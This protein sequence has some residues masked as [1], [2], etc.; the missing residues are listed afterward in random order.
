MEILPRTSS[1]VGGGFPNPPNDPL[2]PLPFFP[3]FRLFL[4]AA[5]PCTHN[6]VGDGNDDSS[7]TNSSSAARSNKTVADS[8]WDLLFFCLL[9]AIVIIYFISVGKIARQTDLCCTVF[10]RMSNTQCC[11]L[12]CDTYQ[13]MVMART[14]D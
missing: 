2:F 7:R 8:G 9:A 6:V 12:M 11:G 1:R 13:V 10:Y 3:P 5:K 14:V 4:A